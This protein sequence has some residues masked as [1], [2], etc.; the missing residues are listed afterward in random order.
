MNQ[1][2]ETKKGRQDIQSKGLMH[3]A[4]GKVFTDSLTQLLIILMTWRAYDVSGTVFSRWLWL[5][6]EGMS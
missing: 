6:W 1:S 2:L 4:R 3:R 5:D